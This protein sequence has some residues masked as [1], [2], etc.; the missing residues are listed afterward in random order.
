L[1]KKIDK[2]ETEVKK[3]PEFEDIKMK[4]ID[5]GKDFIFTVGEQIYYRDR[6][7]PTQPKRCR[8]CLAERRNRIQGNIRV[9]EE[10]D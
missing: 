9:L 10:K 2:Q 6:H 4:C 1:D 8:S 7:I 3:S 5:C